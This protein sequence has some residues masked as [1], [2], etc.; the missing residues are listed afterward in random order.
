MYVTNVI[1]TGTLGAKL[2]LYKIVTDNTNVVYRPHRFIAATWRHPEIPGSLTLFP[3]GKINHLGKPHPVLS[4]K[5]CI[6]L[7]ADILRKQGH[8]V[9]VSNV[10]TVCSSAFHKLEGTVN[11]YDVATLVPGATYEPEIFNAALIKR[12]ALALSIFSTGSVVITGITNIENVYPILIELE[13]LV[14]DASVL[15]K[16]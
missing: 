4:P 15:D 2:N 14:K 3:N 10:S 16:S 5:S 8:P 11:L 9:Q 13:L 6:E 12:G 1:T 7:Y